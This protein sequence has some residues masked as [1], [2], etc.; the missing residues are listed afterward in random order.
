[1]ADVKFGL[2]Q[3]GNTTPRWANRAF[4]LTA[5]LSTVVVF[6][7]SGTTKIPAE[8]KAEIFLYLKGLDM[9]VLGVAKMFGVQLPANTEVPA[10]KVDVIDTK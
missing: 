10:D 5:I 2:N 8:D 9:L 6:V 1:M 4:Q 3:F 7:I